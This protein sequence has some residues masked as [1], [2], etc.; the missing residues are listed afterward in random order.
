MLL[1]TFALEAASC[2]I[3]AVSGCVVTSS[4]SRRPMAP[5]SRAPVHIDK[6]S[7]APDVTIFSPAQNI[8]IL[9]CADGSRSS[10]D[11]D[12]GLD[13]VIKYG[14]RAERDACA[15]MNDAHCLRLSVDNEV[16]LFAF[17]LARCKG[18]KGTNYILVIGSFEQKNSDPSRL[19]RTDCANV[20]FRVLSPV[21]LHRNDI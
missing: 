13:D 20:G 3:F 14:A 7:P 12:L 1:M 19:F 9:R 6:I 18:A 2:M 16:W 21:R 11:D 15:R 17:T 5:R 10:G 8:R 4:P